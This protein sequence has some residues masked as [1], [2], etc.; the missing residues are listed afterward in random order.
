VIYVTGSVACVSANLQNTGHQITSLKRHTQP[1]LQ[2]SV[3]A[4]AL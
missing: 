1:K 2:G 3:P 4:I